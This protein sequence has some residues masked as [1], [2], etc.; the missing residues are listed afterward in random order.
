MVLY[1]S[2]AFSA[3]TITLALAGRIPPRLHPTLLPLPPLTTVKLESLYAL[4]QSEV[5]PAGSNC[6]IRK[7]ASYYKDRELPFSVEEV[8]RAF[9]GR[10]HFFVGDSLSLQHYNALCR[11]LKITFGFH[12]ELRASTDSPVI[13]TERSRC[14]VWNQQ[15]TILCW[16]SAKGRPKELHVGS[17][18]SKLSQLTNCS[19]IL[20]NAGL[21]YRLRLKEL[22]EHV[23]SM[24]N[25]AR[26]LQEAQGSN[27]PFYLWR[28]TTPQFF[29][30]GG[31]YDPAGKLEYCANTQ[32]SSNV[33]NV[34][35][36]E[37]LARVP[38]DVMCVLR[39]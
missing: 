36:N 29:Q 23:Q 28:E 14:A 7:Y 37:I 13:E 15:E 11:V 34:I 32:V 8:E 33:Y 19:S 16:L 18:V 9:I 4:S 27:G 20:L 2:L 38:A 21:H 10:T 35:T 39:C 25:N 22:A 6:T 3:V 12:A 24:V 5:T 30:G 1:R 26:V 31:A 17:A